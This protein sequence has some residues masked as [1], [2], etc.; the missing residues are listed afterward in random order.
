MSKDQ[1]EGGV[2]PKHNSLFRPGPNFHLN[3]CVG[4]NGGPADF[5]RYAFGYFEAG[6]R[7]VKSLQE[8]HASVDLLIYPLVHLYRHGIE[9][10]LKHLGRELPILCNEKA[11]VKQTHKLLDNWASVRHHLQ[12]LQAADAKTLDSVEEKLK[13]IVEIDPNGETFRYPKAKDGKMHLQETS[14][15]NAEVFA[16]EMQGLVEFFE[17]ACTIADAMFDAECETEWP[18]W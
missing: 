9:A 1:Q 13:E 6:E 12:Q 15:I 4:R 10:V 14:I 3:A 8:D 17:N 18:G 2:G 11:T 16:E 5:H 7:L